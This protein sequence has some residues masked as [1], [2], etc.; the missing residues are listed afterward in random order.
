MLVAQVLWAQQQVARRRVKRGA[1]YLFSDPKWPRMWYLVSIVVVGCIS[2][3]CV[4]LSSHAGYS[5][6]C[7]CLS[8]VDTAEL[9][10][11]VLHV[12]NEA[13]LDA[14]LV[15]VYCCCQLF[16]RTITVHAARTFRYFYSTLS[17]TS[18]GHSITF[19]TKAENFEDSCVLLRIMEK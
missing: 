7:L 1:L 4:V 11:D 3:R 6:A 9:I 16:T 14:S 10:S 13:A 18:K 12:A 15:F 5:N 8:W 17:K 19:I 2:P